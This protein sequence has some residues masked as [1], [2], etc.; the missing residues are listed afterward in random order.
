MFGGAAAWNMLKKGV[1]F[2]AD[3]RGGGKSG[4]SGGNGVRTRGGNAVEDQN[5]P[6]GYDAFARTQNAKTQKQQ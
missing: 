4:S 1:G 5:A 2:I 6:D 3:K